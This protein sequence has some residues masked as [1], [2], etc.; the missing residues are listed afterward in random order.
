MKFA[1][2]S[3]NPFKTRIKQ[4]KTQYTVKLGDTAY[5]PCEIENRRESTVMWQF[6]RSRI[7]ETLT[8]GFLQYRQDYRMRIVTNLTVDQ[9]QTWDLEIRK[10][11]LDDEGYYI[12]RVM[13]DPESLKRSVHLKVEV[14]VTLTQNEMLTT[15]DERKIELF[16]NTSYS[17]PSADSNLQIKWLKDN[18]EKMSN[19]ASQSYQIEEFKT[20]S[21]SSKLIFFH[22]SPSHA[23]TYHCIFN[24]QNASISLGQSQKGKYKQGLS[25]IL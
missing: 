8:V 13:A 11:R 7:P 23:G 5:L 6:T 10:V 22:F 21:L 14:E 12:C 2:A 9:V 16:C 1:R 20:P 15:D 18:I 3:D 17:S 4:E 19:G 25:K 24:N